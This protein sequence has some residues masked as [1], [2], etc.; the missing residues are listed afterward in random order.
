MGRSRSRERRSPSYESYANNNKSNYIVIKVPSS[1][2]ALIVGKNGQTKRKLEAAAGVKVQIDQSPANPDLSDIK[3]STAHEMR[4][5]AAT[6]YIKH[7]LQNKTRGVE[8]NSKGDRM[9]LTV[10]SIPQA[11]SFSRI[12]SYFFSDHWIYHWGQKV[13]SQCTRGRDQNPDV[14]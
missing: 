3:I 2:A 6:D 1:E 14:F 9:D 13:Y 4:R 7:L 12:F 10:M 5:E 11:V 8:I